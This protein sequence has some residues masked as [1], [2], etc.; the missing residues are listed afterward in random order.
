MKGSEKAAGRSV[1]W[2]YVK[3]GHFTADYFPTVPGPKGPTAS[4]PK[5][6]EVLRDYEYRGKGGDLPTAFMLLYREDIERRPRRKG[7]GA[8]ATG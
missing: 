6:V 4:E 8:D 7:H 5:Q 1:T 2:T 3:A